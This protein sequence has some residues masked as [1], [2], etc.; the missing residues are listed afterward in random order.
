MSPF[1]IQC[2]PAGFKPI[3][4]GQQLA[5]RGKDF[6]ARGLSLF[7]LR[8]ILI[9]SIA[10]RKPVVQQRPGRVHMRVPAMPV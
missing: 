1:L 2:H 9:P 5:L 7:Q 6:L 8:Q 3:A 10:S 4:L